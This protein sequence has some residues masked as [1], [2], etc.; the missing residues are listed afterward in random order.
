M[1]AIMKT[2]E[3]TFIDAS[4]SILRE[5]SGLLKSKASW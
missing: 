1:K 2:T 5:I 3:M 4:M